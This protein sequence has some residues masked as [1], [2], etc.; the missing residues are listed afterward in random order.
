MQAS[1][2]LQP[3]EFTPFLHRLLSQGAWFWCAMFA[4]VVAGRLLIGYYEPHINS[5]D[6]IAAV[7]PSFRRLVVA[8]T[9]FWPTICMTERNV[10]A[11]GKCLS[12][13]SLA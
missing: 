13:A 1:H 7:V 8:A 9:T 12:A 6:C 3:D 11:A 2:R 5:W 10:V 4:T